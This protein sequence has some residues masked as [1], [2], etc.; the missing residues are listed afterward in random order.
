MVTSA[1][2]IDISQLSGETR[3]VLDV[4]D[5]SRGI[6]ER[7]LAAMGR[8]PRYR[9]TAASTAAVK[10]GDVKYRTS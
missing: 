7:T 8:V 9:E 5:R 1:Q 4:Y 2:T 6:Y 10:V 3:R